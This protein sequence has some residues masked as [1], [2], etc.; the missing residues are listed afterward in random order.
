MFEAGVLVED[1]EAKAPTAKLYGAYQ[2]WANAASVPLDR[3]YG[4]D[5]FAKALSGRFQRCKLTGGVRG[6]NGV[7]VGDVPLA[8]VESVELVT[9]P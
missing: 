1:P 2:A 3:R 5:G 9:L 8:P 6:F 4:Q 7:R